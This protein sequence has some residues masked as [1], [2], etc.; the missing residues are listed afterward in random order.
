M[1]RFEQKSTPV[2]HGTIALLVAAVFVADLYTH[3]GLAVW[4]T[5]LLPVVLS[6]FGWRP[7]AP[8]VVACLASILLIVGYFTSPGGLPFNWGHINR[9]IGAFT[10]WVVAV[11]SYQFIR[12]KLKVRKQQEVLRRS[13]DE[14]EERTLELERR[15]RDLQD[16]AFIA[17]H[18]L[19]EPLRKIQTLGSLL[20]AKGADRLSE[21]E[22]DYISR[23]TGSANRMHE[24][25]NA[26]LSY[27]RIETKGERFSPVKLDEVIWD[28]VTDL[29]VAI[30]NVQAHVEVEPLPIVKGDPHQ[31]RQLFQNLVA[32]ALKYRRAGVRPLIKIHGE[33]HNE[34]G[35][36]FVEDNGI[37]FDEKYID[38]I[39][40]PFQRLHGK[41]EYSG[42]GIGLAICKKI[43]ER[44]GG[45]IT[46]KSTPGRGSTFIIE[47]PKS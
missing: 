34:T 10:V 1:T 11:I 2:I 27:S 36:I 21:Q 28:S 47:V 19:S 33:I 45:T 32:N 8:L 30:R 42:T 25:L 18:D 40:Q 12:N 43:I 3:L 22:R 35:R 15:N 37:G 24:L 6:I 39:F 20:E 29:E 13:R 26:F 17:A 41:N 46:A 5:Y 4:I 14:L 9:G 31:L 44:H 7:L 23:M 16:F 38:K